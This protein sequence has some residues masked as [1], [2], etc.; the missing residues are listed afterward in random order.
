[1]RSQRGLITFN[2]A[3]QTGLTPA[4]VNRL[5]R[6]DLW[7]KVRSGVYA[8]AQAW[9]DLDPWI[10]QPA[11][12]ARATHMVTSIEHWFSHDSAAA[13]HGISVFR[14]S[15]ERVH[16][17]RPDMRGRQVRPGLTQHG[18]K[19]HVGEA[20]KIDGLPALSPARTA[21]DLVREH[22]F[23][24][25]LGACDQ[26]LR[27]GVSRDELWQAAE[28]MRGWPYSVTVREA[29]EMADA[30]A[31]NPFESAA[32]A[33][34]LE[35]GIGAPETQFGLSDG[36][37]TAFCDMRVGRHIFEADGK[38]KLRPTSEGGY[39]ADPERALWEE[40]KRQDFVSGFKLGVSRITY[41]DV[42]SR[43][44]QALRRLAREYDDTVARFGT[45]ISDLAPYVIRRAA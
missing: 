24:T 21:L 42:T 9:R 10:G 22:G 8:D 34:V 17:T 32:R 14:G 3:L 29:V 27:L 18:A 37:R 12:R 41:V 13:L 15:P 20:L 30:G 4:Q 2:Q 1:M 25:G 44:D 11:L 45:S 19:V 16:F 33:L 5:L 6:R 36:Q 43:R 7:S 31:E 28:Y 26:V 23:D 40:K 38:V 35:L 39:A